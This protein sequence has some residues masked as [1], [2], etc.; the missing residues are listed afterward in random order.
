VFRQVRDTKAPRAG[1]EPAHLGCVNLIWLLLTF[2]DSDD[3]APE[4]SRRWR[5]PPGGTGRPPVASP[6][7]VPLWRPPA[8]S[9]AASPRDGRPA[10]ASPRDGWPAESFSFLG[11]VFRSFG[12]RTRGWSPRAC[13]S[14]SRVPGQGGCSPIHRVCPCGDRGAAEGYSMITCCTPRYSRCTTRDHGARKCEA[15]VG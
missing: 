6:C 13:F 9:P 3:M 14:V 10:A 15:P 4:R 2:R 11:L 8:A 7:G 1:F 12:V 5:P